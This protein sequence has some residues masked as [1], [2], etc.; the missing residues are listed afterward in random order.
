M[1]WFSRSTC[2]QFIVDCFADYSTEATVHGVKYIGEQK[3]HPCTKIFWALCFVLSITGCIFMMVQMYDKWLENSM[4]LLPGN[5]LE[6]YHDIPFPAVTVC[7]MAKFKRSKI[8]FEEIYGKF[9]NINTSI[10]TVM[11]RNDVENLKSLEAFYHLNN[12]FVPVNY[13]YTQKPFLDA[14]ETFER[15]QNMSATFGNSLEYDYYLTVFNN[16][17]HLDFFDGFTK[18]LTKHGICWTFNMYAQSEIYEDVN[19]K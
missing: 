15:I 3:R 16:F 7:P 8:D 1:F 13:P 17:E 2:Y 19:I 6:L 18:T 14:D 9:K 4:I 11:N 10:P 5:G 12:N